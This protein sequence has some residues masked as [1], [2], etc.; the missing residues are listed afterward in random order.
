MRNLR[1]PT[2]PNDVGSLG[3]ENGVNDQQKVTKE[4]IADVISNISEGVIGATVALGS[5]FEKVGYV[6]GYV[7]ALLAMDLKGSD[8]WILW[9]DVCLSQASMFVAFLEDYLNGEFK[10]KDFKLSFAQ[11]TKYREVEV[12]RIIRKKYVHP[13]VH[14]FR[15]REQE[16]K[17]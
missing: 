6:Q 11:L 7:D 16:R 9:K 5:L 3:M 2:T 17:R 1:R 14:R 12:A 8:F 10:C 15:A 13:A 4:E